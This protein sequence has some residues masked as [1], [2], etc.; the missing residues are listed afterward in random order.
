MKKVVLEFDDDEVELLQQQLNQIQDV[1]GMETLEDYVYYATMSH[2]KTMQAT[3]RM[4]GQAG[5][6]EKLMSDENVHVGVVNMPIQ[7][8]NV[9][10]KDDFSQY[11]NDVLNDAVK[12][13]MNRNNEPI[14]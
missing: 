4:F 13:Y 9:E 14:N 12:D 8:S 2:C 5:D 7:L 11:L 10:D 3:S 1:T 6:L